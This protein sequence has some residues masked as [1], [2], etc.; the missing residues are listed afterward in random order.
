MRV[1][2]LG[3]T[4]FIGNNVLNY[5]RA[6]TD[7]D[8]Y[9]TYNNR[10]PDDT[11]FA[12]WHKVN[13]LKDDF[14]HIFEGIDVA[15]VCAA[16]SSGAKDIVER[17]DIFVTDNTLINHAIFSNATEAGVSHVLY[18][19]CSV[20]YQ[21]CDRIQTE[22]DVD[23]SKIYPRYQ[24]GASMKLYAEGLCKFYAETTKT[25]F[26]VFRH[27]NT[28]GPLDKFDL[29]RSH[30][31]AASILKSY[32]ESETYTIWGD[33]QEKRDFVYVDDLCALVLMIINKPP[34]NFELVCAGSESMI[35]IAELVKTILSIRGIKKEISYDVTA[36]SLPVN[37][38]L[39]H[40]KAST[41][42]G[43]YPKVDIVSGLTRTINWYEENRR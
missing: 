9:A 34:N 11:S 22:T 23:V 40:A 6:H 43:W 1:L 2:V 10:L 4:G 25:R 30:V 39:S 37:I 15:I 42:Y 26:T 32:I 12:T 29:G 24:G 27:T 31:L 41:L 7:Y 36:P 8:L 3:G 14:R 20:M 21:S 35:S 28:Y 33:G 18:P 13:F 5:L 19:S 17:P 16:V 38:C